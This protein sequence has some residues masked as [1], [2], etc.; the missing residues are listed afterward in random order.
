MS[1][2]ASR[3]WPIKTRTL[4]SDETM[5]RMKP[6]GQSKASDHR[7]WLVMPMFLSGIASNNKNHPTVEVDQNGRAFV[8]TIVN[9]TS[10]VLQNHAKPFEW[11]HDDESRFTTHVSFYGSRVCW[12]TL[13]A[14]PNSPTS[15]NFAEA[16]EAGHPGIVAVVTRRVKG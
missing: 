16:S 2:A 15:I 7:W 13:L 9:A 3:S 5:I 10:H 1:P 11:E 12:D 6:K 4:I 8:R 14:N